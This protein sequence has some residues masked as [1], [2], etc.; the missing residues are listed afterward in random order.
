LF[1]PPPG[2]DQ[3]LPSVFDSS[4]LLQRRTLSLYLCKIPDDLLIIK[5]SVLKPNNINPINQELSIYWK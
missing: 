2:I 3:N 1:Q 4:L 5:S